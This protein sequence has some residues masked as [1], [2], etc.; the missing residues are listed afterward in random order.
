MAIQFA[1]SR[2]RML[3]LD[4]NGDWCGSIITKES[5]SARVV[6]FDYPINYHGRTTI[7]DQAQILSKMKELQNVLLNDLT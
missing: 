2:F 1:G 4:E 7:E 5:D 6:L 3:C